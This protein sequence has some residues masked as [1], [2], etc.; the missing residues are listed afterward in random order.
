M[1]TLTIALPP[2]YNFAS[3]NPGIE[4]FLFPIY[5]PFCSSLLA[6]TVIDF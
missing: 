6:S 2:P 4:T 3:V 5:L 1:G